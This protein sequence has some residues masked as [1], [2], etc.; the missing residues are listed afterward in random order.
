MALL[1]ITWCCRLAFSVM[2]RIL[3]FVSK[4]KIRLDYHWVEL[5]PSLTSTLHFIAQ[6]LEELQLKEEFPLFL[7]SVSLVHDSLVSVCIYSIIAVCQCVQ[8]VR[9]SWRNISVRHQEL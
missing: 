2:H 7:A 6:R 8:H 9:Y 1:L 4:H 3:S 5:W